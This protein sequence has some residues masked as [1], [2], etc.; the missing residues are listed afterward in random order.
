MMARFGISTLG[1]SAR[2]DFS[3]MTNTNQ[4]II[5]KSVVSIVFRVRLELMITRTFVMHLILSKFSS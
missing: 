4:T 2:R 3:M 5:A 1:N